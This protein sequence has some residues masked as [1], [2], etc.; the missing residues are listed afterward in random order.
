[1]DGLSRPISRQMSLSSNWEDIAKAKKDDKG[2]V[3]HQS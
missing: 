3:Y 1:M 2:L